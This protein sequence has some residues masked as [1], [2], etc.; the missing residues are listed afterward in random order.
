M[1]VPP[2]VREQ[3]SDFHFGS[4]VYSS[5]GQHIGSLH[6][7]IVD[8]ESWTP[9]G[10][11]VK[12]AARFSGQ[13]LAGE[14][15]VLTDDLVVP[16]SALARVGHDRV[17]LS[18]TANEARRLPPYLSYQYP[19]VNARELSIE[20]VSAAV[21]G[22]A[23]PMFIE[24]ANKAPGEI[25]IA[26][27]ENVMLGHEGEKLGHVREVLVEDGALIGVVVHP[28]G[29]L[30]MFKRDL[31][32][33]LRFLERSDDAALFVRLGRDDLKQLEPFQSGD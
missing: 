19:P 7:L 24:E 14:A 15:G 22:F 18:L 31:V 11:I 13:H 4:P 27:G 26:Q 5:D 29:L 33:P 32:V 28:S 20:V 12:E 30:S 25:E 6:R 9:H 3:L 23:P 10:V 16:L 17:D 8:Q 21:A 2:Q 1:S